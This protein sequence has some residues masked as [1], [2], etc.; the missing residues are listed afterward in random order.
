MITKKLLVCVA[1]SSFWLASYSEG[2]SIDFPDPIGPG[3]GGSGDTYVAPKTYTY[4]YN[5]LN[6]VETNVPT[7]TTDLLGDKIDTGTGS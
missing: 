3:L 2:V 4:N 7:L 6:N 5:E 1:L